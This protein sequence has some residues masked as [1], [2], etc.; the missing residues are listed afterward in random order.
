M[1]M[2][3]R[4]FFKR[5]LAV[6]TV[7]AGLFCGSTFAAE[8]ARNS[9]RDTIKKG[10][11]KTLDQQLADELEDE[12]FDDLEKGPAPDAKKPAKPGEPAEEVDRKMLEEFGDG[13]DILTSKKADLTSI[14]DKMRTV[15]R[16]VKEK[17]LSR[18]TRD[19]QKQIVAELEEL[20]KEVRRQTPSQSSSRQTARRKDSKHRSQRSVTL[21]PKKGQENRT[22]PARVPASAR[23]VGGPDEP[24]VK[25]E[26]KRAESWGILPEKEEAEMMRSAARG[27][28]L[29][30]YRDR[31]EQYFRD[32]EEM[33][34]DT[35]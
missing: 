34:R 5:I 14:G 15:S 28:F 6:A 35:R 1:H 20:L 3:P 30:E 29:P 26:A 22:N 21:Q 16:R 17:D 31:I 32:I 25:G 4:S 27:E 18:K 33:D 8:P 2:S 11:K 19:M 24:N 13:E 12:L 7:A 9:P 10:P 23:G